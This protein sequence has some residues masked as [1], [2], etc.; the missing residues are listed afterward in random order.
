MNIIV[1]INLIVF[2]HSCLLLKYILKQL[3]LKYDLLFWVLHWGNVSQ[4]RRLKGLFYFPSEEKIADDAS[5][6]TAWPL[7]YRHIVHGLIN[8]RWIKPRK[9]TSGLAGWLD[10]FYHLWILRLYSINQ[11]I[12]F[13]RLDQSGLAT[14]ILINIQY[15]KWRHL[16]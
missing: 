16:C 6:V 11:S 15:T 1:K 14:H 7:F 8:M 12:S 10:I 5:D 4:N 2:I 9:N 3:K 13:V